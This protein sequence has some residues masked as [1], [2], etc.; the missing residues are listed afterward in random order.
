METNVKSKSKSNTEKEA[1]SPSFDYRAAIGS[2][3]YLAT[4][5]RP[6]IRFVN[7][8][9]KKHYGAVKQILRYLVST[10]KQGIMYSASNEAV[11]SIIVSGYCDADWANDPDSRNT[12]TGY[13]LTVAGGAI[14]WVARRHTTTTMSTTEAEYM[15]AS[16]ATMEGRGIVNMFDEVVNL[17]KVETKLTMGVDNNAAIALAKAPTYSSRTR[18]I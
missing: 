16:E 14:T 12:I 5:T 9:T 6:H 7:N 1:D 17:V 4:S 10:R 8:P 18:Y 11:S 13:V 3:I 2:L 15:A